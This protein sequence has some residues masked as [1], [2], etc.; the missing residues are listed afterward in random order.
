MAHCLWRY[1]WRI[2][3]C[4][5]TPCIVTGCLLVYIALALCF[6]ITH[7]Y[8]GGPSGTLIPL[9]DD[10]FIAKGTNS[11]SLLAPH[12]MRPF[13]KEELNR[14]AFWNLIQHVM[15]RQHNTILR[16]RKNISENGNSTLHSLN[17]TGCFSNSD[18]MWNP[19]DYFS[20]PPQIQRFIKYMR[21]RD[22]P[23]LINQPG[24]CVS[25]QNQS[26]APMLLLV[27]KSQA[28]NIKNRQAIRFTWGHSG[29]VRGQVGR[30]GLVRRVFLL[31]KTEAG[32]KADVEQE[33][34]T[35]GDIIMWDFLD[36][37]FNLT[38]KDV[39]FWDWYA[40]HCANSR[41]VFKGDDDVFVR[42]PA[43]LDYLDRQKSKEFV[44]GD[45]ITAALPVRSENTKYF[46]PHGFYKGSYPSY[47]GGGGVVYSGALVPRLLA[48][49]KRVH[50]YPIDDVY[51][52]MCLERLGVI[53]IHNPAFLTFDFTESEAKEPC[54]HHTILMV[55]KRSP[56][57]M[58]KLWIETLEPK[59]ECRN[60]PLRKAL[61]L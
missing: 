45:L 41:F 17:K 31:G 14:E 37:F 29:L 6:A 60:T 57:E 28:E 7:T 30:G 26:E 55:H 24:V 5:C 12:P 52:G 36:T 3:L 54:A 38:L 23:L 21:C 47:P 15:D 16:A 43:L 61:T 53:P 35:Y 44:A 25:K 34:K 2:L 51:L 1:R 4:I 50:L 27:I 42:T 22:Y 11:S 18:K 58:L 59:S 9:L 8:H 13:W 48:I 10:Y 46:I 32:S 39:L 20:L 19:S 40:K 49:S 56:E 33:S